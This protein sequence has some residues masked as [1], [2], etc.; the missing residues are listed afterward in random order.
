MAYMIYQK[1][2]DTNELRSIVTNDIKKLLKLT[3]GYRTSRKTMV[4]IPASS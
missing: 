4:V 2:D 3:N 1:S